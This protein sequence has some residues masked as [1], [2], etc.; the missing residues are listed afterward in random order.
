[1][2]SHL[3]C[4]SRG[5]GGSREYG[6]SVHENISA[7]GTAPPADSRPP[8]GPRRAAGPRQALGGQQA[9]GGAPPSRPQ[10]QRHP[11][12]GALATMAPGPALQWVGARA[13][14]CEGTRAAGA[15]KRHVSTGYGIEQI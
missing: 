7:V 13:R 1:M 12:R 4:W 10:R 3:Y 2:S 14:I 9:L 8:A 11:G 6:R 5:V 15:A